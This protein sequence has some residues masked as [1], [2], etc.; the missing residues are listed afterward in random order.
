VDFDKVLKWNNRFHK[1]SG[2]AQKADALSSGG[3]FA[4]D[5]VVGAGQITDATEFTHH[6]IEMFKLDHAGKGPM[7]CMVCD[8]LYVGS[9]YCPECGGAGDPV[10]EREFKDSDP[11]AGNPFTD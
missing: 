5:L 2:L 10:K 8:T 7:A 4:S 11:F 1:V 6:M 3:A 9:L